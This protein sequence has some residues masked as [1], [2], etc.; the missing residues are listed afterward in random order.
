MNNILHHKLL[1]LPINIIVFSLMFIGCPEPPT[2]PTPT[3]ECPD[4]YHPCDSEADTLTCCPDEIPATITQTHAHWPGLADTPW[5][6]YMHDPQHTGRSQ[7]DGPELGKV[8]WALNITSEI[9]SNPVI[10]PNGNIIVSARLDLGG[11]QKLLSVTPEG[12]INW[13]V[14]FGGH[15]D[16]SPLISADNHIYVCHSEQSNSR[17]L[18]LVKLDLAGNIIWKYDLSEYHKG[19]KGTFSPN[20]SIDGKT[21]FIS[22]A[23]S[24]LFAINTNGNLKWKL[25]TSPEFYNGELSISPNGE[26]IYLVTNENRLVSVDT[27]GVLNWSFYIGTPSSVGWNGHNY[28]ETSLS[29]PTIDSDG[30]IYTYS[31]LGMHSISPEGYLRWEYPMTNFSLDYNNGITIGPFGGIFMTSFPKIA[32]FNFDGSL[33]WEKSYW[34]QN[35]FILDRQGN[36]YLGIFASREYTPDNSI[37]NFISFKPSGVIKYIIRLGPEESYT[38][39]IDSPG[40]IYNDNTYFVGSDP[41]SPILFFKIK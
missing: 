6:M 20:I 19:T 8:E 26:S 11:F 2:E 10:D 5:P 41:G 25:S 31:N 36:S 29:A 38:P 13:E 18:Y 24:S 33:R 40:C 14:E 23:D 30:N 7:Y 37:I 21:I 3:I 22:G 9:F 4:G 15:I 34:N 32:V 17:N 35:R 27:S 28:H 1:F 16:S 39:D 12:T